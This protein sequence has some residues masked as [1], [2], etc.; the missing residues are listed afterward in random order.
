MGERG[1]GEGLT[2]FIF[3]RL[4]NGGRARIPGGSV[5]G[6]PFHLTIH[7]YY[8]WNQGLEK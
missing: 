5:G 3:E 4:E 8:R 7:G 6:K 2:I 1:T